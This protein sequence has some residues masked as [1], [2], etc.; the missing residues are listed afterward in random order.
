MDMASLVFESGASSHTGKVRQANEDN[1][2]MRPGLGLWVVSDGMG[3]HQAGKLAS[4]VVCEELGGVAAQADAV[5]L[6]RQC[7]AKL[8]RANT[9]LRVAAA[10]MGLALIG[11]TV[12]ILLAHGASYACVWSGDSRIYRVREGE[13]SQLTRDHSEAEE[14]VAQGML[15][16]EEAARWP[17]RN[18]ITRAI[19]VTEEVELEMV[20][21]LIETGDTYVLCSDGLTIHVSDEEIRDMVNGHDAQ[22]ACDALIALALERGGKDNVTAIVVQTRRREPTVLELGAHVKPNWATTS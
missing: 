15:T 5:G 6:L 17:R 13:I 19:G 7:E 3:G 4:M 21:G 22:V 1:F 12:V 16:R 9:R 14:L 20:D 11:A 18:V 10:E 2:L 8:V